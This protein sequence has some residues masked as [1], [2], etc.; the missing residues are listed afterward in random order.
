MLLWWLCII[1]PERKKKYLCKL[2]TR[3][4]TYTEMAK[5]KRMSY[6][7]SLS[8]RGILP[9]REKESIEYRQQQ[10]MVKYNDMQ[11]MF[12]KIM[13][14][15]TLDRPSQLFSEIYL[16]ESFFWFFVRFCSRCFAK[17]I[18]KDRN[19][20]LASLELSN[21]WWKGQNRKA[22]KKKNENEN[23]NYKVIDGKR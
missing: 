6:I 1:F 5:P 14:M 23:L 11:I 8:I 22:M 2:S 7:E 15:S 19:R 13:K 21:K 4:Y 16:F 12:S 18:N 10:Y 17:Y 3:I 9:T 20:Q